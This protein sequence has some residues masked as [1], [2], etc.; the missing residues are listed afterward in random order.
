MRMLCFLWPCL[1]PNDLICRCKNVVTLSRIFNCKY[2]IT[3]RSI[4][5]DS[6]RAQLYATCKSVNIEAF[7]EPLLRKLSPDQ[8]DYFFGKRRANLLAPGLDG[9]LHIVDV[10]SVDVCILLI[11]HS[12]TP[13][14]KKI[15]NMKN[16]WHN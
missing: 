13:K 6:V 14:K 3:Y 4:V 7:I 5:Y 10:V 1:L 8:T 9:V 16:H 11:R 15:K 12:L 2:F